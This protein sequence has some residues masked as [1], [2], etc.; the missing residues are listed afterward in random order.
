MADVKESFTWYHFDL[1]LVILSEPACVTVSF[2]TQS[3]RLL[4]S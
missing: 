4:S 1:E 3:F 2:Q